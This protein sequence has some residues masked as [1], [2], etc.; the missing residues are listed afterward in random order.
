MFRYWNNRKARI[1]TN[2]VLNQMFVVS[3]QQQQQHM[4][5]SPQQLPQS[6][7]LAAGTGLAF[8]YK[9][10]G[11]YLHVSRLVRPLWKKRCLTANG[12]SS[13]TYNQCADVLDELYA[14]RDFIES[15]PMNNATGFLQSME[16]GNESTVN[17]YGHSASFNVRGAGSGVGFPNSEQAAIEEKKSIGMLSSF[18]SEFDLF[19]I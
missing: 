7:D 5:H 17:Q 2:I 4:Q 8:S 15:L 19:S 3:S 13:I 11:L 9:H 6:L 1:Q 14:V 18:I 10:D 16:A 12:H